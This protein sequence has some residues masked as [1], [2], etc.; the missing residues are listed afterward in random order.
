MPTINKKKKSMDKV[1]KFTHLIFTTQDTAFPFAVHHFPYLPLTSP[2]IPVMLG[3][4]GVNPRLSE[5]SV[6]FIYRGRKISSVLEV[7]QS[8]LES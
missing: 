6:S 2:Q 7:Q 3:I 5:Y 4:Q 8:K 1:I